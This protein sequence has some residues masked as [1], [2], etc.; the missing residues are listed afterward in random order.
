M[1]TASTLKFESRAATKVAYTTGRITDAVAKWLRHV[2][3]MPQR[4]KWK[5]HVDAAYN[6]QKR[7]V[8]YREDLLRGP[9]SD[10]V[11]RAHWL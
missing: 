1:N 3:A 8:M 5:S 11:R 4:Q 7:Y 9:L 2:I 10:E 6:P